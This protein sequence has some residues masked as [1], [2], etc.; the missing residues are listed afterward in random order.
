MYAANYAVERWGPVSVG[1]G[2]MAPAGVYFAG[3]A[4]TLRDVVQRTLGKYVAAAA[5]LVGAALSWQISPSLATASA[6]AFLVSEFSDLVVFTLLERRSVTAALVASNV[7]GLVVDSL[8]FLSIA[9]GSLEFFKGQVV[10]KAWMTLAALPVV[11]L[12]RRIP[13]EREPAA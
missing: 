13:I 3:L 1:F 12:L 4:F 11:L 5:I 9:F 2:L 8:V 7:V 6:V 10:G